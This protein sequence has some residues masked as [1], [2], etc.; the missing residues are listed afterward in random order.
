MVIRLAEL[1]TWVVFSGARRPRGVKVIRNKGK[2]EGHVD[3][4]RF[5]VDVDVVVTR[6]QCL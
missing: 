3:R 5:G 6:E 2:C 4:C 1:L